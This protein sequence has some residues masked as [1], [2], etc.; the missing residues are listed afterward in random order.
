MPDGSVILGDKPAAGA[1]S[2]ESSQVRSPESAPVARSAADAEREYWRQQAE[3]FERRQRAEDAARMRGWS[4]SDQGTGAVDGSRPRRAMDRRRFAVVYRGSWGAYEAPAGPSESGP[5]YLYLLAR[6]REW[7]RGRLHRQRLQYRALIGC[8]AGR[9]GRVARSGRQ[10]RATSIGTPGTTFPWL[11]L[12]VPSGAGFFCHRPLEGYNR[13]FTGRRTLRFSRRLTQAPSCDPCRG[14][15][16]QFESENSMV[17]V[18]LSR[19]GA[20]KRPFYNIVVTDKRNRRDGSFIERLGF[21][22]PVASAEREAP[23]ACRSVPGPALGSRVRRSRRA[24]VRL[25]RDFAAKSDA[26]EGDFGSGRAR[27]RSPILHFGPAD[28]WRPLGQVR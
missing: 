10:A 12:P 18:R 17:V 19:G 26:A 6:R 16:V 20:K 2:V 14:S 22:N 11:E 25:V 24:T 13:M 8:R 28:P 27:C 21:Y 9:A 3:G 4:Y 23:A 1:R 15:G 7:P 5:A